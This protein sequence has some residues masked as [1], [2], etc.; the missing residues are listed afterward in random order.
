M[1]TGGEVDHLGISADKRDELE[2]RQ[3]F[4]QSPGKLDPLA[5]GND[6]IGIAKT[7]DEMVQIA[8]RLTIA[9]DMVMADQ[10]KAFE[11][12]DHILIIIRNDD[13]HA[14]DHVTHRRR[15]GASPRNDYLLPGCSEP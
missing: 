15:E 12:I 7:F 4:Q 1:G 8:R 5:N 9:C 2:L 3:L 6:D 13:F 10:R 11:L 14:S